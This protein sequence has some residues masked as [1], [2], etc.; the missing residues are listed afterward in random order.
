MNLTAVEDR[1]TSTK[2][3]PSWVLDEHHVARL[4]DDPNGENCTV[5]GFA[6]GWYHIPGVF[7]EGAVDSHGHATACD[8]ADV[9]EWIARTQDS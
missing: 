9:L 1:N 3:F 4:D 7:G 5:C 2:I 8:L 6:A